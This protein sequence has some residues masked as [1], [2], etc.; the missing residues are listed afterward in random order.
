MLVI[1]HER[2]ILKQSIDSDE[3]LWMQLKTH[4]GPQKVLYALALQNYIDK[5]QVPLTVDDLKWYSIDANVKSVY[6][7]LHESFKRTF[8]K[9]YIE[10]H[11]FDPSVYK[12]C[13]V[14]TNEHE[15]RIDNSHPFHQ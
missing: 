8:S 15:Y 10:F 5:Y 4:D 11:N 1:D 6:K 2:Q 13:P 12:V 3:T 9:F 14:Y 7:I